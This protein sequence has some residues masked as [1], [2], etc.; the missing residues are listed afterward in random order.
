[1]CVGGVFIVGNWWF[2]PKLVSLLLLCFV[3]LS[4]V[5]HRCSPGCCKMGLF[6]MSRPACTWKSGLHEWGMLCVCLLLLFSGGM[7]KL[8]FLALAGTYSTQI[9]WGGR[10]V[11]LETSVQGREE[12]CRTAAKHSPLPSPPARAPCPHVK[13]LL[14]LYNKSAAEK[15][16]LCNFHTLPLGC[17]IWSP[18]GLRCWSWGRIEWVADRGVTD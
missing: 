8:L 3:N 16:W 6:N 13:W 2:A 12:A 10:K 11:P 7:S 14:V 5:N 9:K 1:M 18:P 4:L 17:F 15:G